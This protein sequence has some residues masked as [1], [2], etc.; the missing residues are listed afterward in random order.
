M[1]GVEVNIM[2]EEE[3]ILEEEEKIAGQKNPPRCD[4]ALTLASKQ[5]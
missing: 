1:Q 5:V 2:Q 4:T 3:I